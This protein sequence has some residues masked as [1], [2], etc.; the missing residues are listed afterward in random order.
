MLES[1]HS[2][3]MLIF[4]LYVILVHKDG[5]YWAGVIFLVTF[6]FVKV[7]HRSVYCSSLV[8]DFFGVDASVYKKVT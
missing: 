2:T 5:Y 3:E 8:E 6:F 1:G 7:R 4:N